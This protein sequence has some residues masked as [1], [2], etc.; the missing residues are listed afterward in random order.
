M[1]HGYARLNGA[2][3]LANFCFDHLNVN[4]RIYRSICL[5]YKHAHTYKCTHT[6]TCTSTCMRRHSL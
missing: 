3:I 5:L 1:H 4:N 2:R 6:R